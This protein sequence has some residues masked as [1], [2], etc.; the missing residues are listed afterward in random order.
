MVRVSFKPSFAAMWVDNC[1]QVKL[2]S[3]ETASKM[4]LESLALC[5]FGVTSCPR[6]SVTRYCFLEEPFRHTGECPI[7]EVQHQILWTSITS[8]QG[9]SHPG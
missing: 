7:P 5:S 4:F 3:S 8:M 1:P 9:S 6:L 2:H